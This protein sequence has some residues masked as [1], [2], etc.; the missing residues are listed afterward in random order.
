M[1]LHFKLIPILFII[2]VGLAAVGQKEIDVVL[3]EISR[4]EEKRSLISQNRTLSKRE[5]KRE[6][7]KINKQIL[8]YQKHLI[9]VLAEDQVF[10][11]KSI[12]N[13]KFNL[14]QQLQ[15]IL[16][17]IVTSIQRV[18][19]RPRKIEKLKNS[20]E[21]SQEELI[22]IEKA[23]SSLTDD[24]LKRKGIDLTIDENL[25]DQVAGLNSIL[26]EQ[27][28][29]VLLQ[30]LKFERELEQLRKNQEPW[31]KQVKKILSG[32]FL[33]KVWH[34]F[35]SLIS[36]L[37][38]MVLALT[39]KKVIFSGRIKFGPW[40]KA[41]AYTY[42]GICFLFSSAF[43]IM[44]LYFFND[45]FLVTL[46][47]LFISGFV[48][49]LRNVLPL[50]LQEFKLIM[51][52]GP[53][54]EG[55]RI[56]WQ[57]LPYK[58]VKLAIRSTVENPALTGGKYKIA[59][60][61]MLDLTSRPCSENE[62]W[63]PT[64]TGDWIEF[65]NDGQICQVVFQGVE[66]VELNERYGGVR[67]VASSQFLEMDFEILSSGFWVN[68]I[69]S[70][71]H[72]HKHNIVTEIIPSIKEELL[73]KM[74][75]EGINFKNRELL[76]DFHALTDDSLEVELKLFCEGELAPQKRNIHHLLQKNLILIFEE[77]GFSIPLRKLQV[78]YEN[79]LPT[80]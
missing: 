60:K 61:N 39:L 64:V 37:F 36:F 12:E 45:W 57:G 1:S 13:V 59:A 22:K 50:F 4:T 27:R 71:D 70:L 63:F 21:V 66:Y 2:Q 48:W 74:G 24:G 68:F 75:T 72:L 26:D 10:E 65:R 51:N 77:K 19:R 73:D 55:E 28:N 43:S 6:L 33:N 20:I 7:R 34:L 29:D 8:N 14:W 15:D 52:M 16:K 25:K 49:S 76:L 44:V 5:R 67:R 53:V 69:F 42:T 30:K 54:R 56:V 31:S 18:S 17:P 78:R 80:N 9:N 58:V 38:F 40:E 35:V 3:Q 32:F 79:N 47:L 46:F 11:E 41:L 62:R 23:T